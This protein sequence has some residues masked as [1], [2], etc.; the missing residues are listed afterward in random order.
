[1]IPTLILWRASDCWVRLGVDLVNGRIV[2]VL[3]ASFWILDPASPTAAI[4]RTSRS[5]LAP[6]HDEPSTRHRMWSL[7]APRSRS[8]ATAATGRLQVP[9]SLVQG[10]AVQHWHAPHF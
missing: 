10:L 3:A 9:F 1:M 7:S 2:P 5:D 4:P 8:S 6:S